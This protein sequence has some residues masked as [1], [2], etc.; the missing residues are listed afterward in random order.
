MSL[1]DNGQIV[2]VMW[3]NAQGVSFRRE[4]KVNFAHQYPGESGKCVLRLVD[5]HGAFEKAIHYSMNC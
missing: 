2:E 4:M 5:N 1:P 3:K